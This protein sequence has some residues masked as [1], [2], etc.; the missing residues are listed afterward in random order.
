MDE[1]RD[2]RI[3][4]GGWKISVNGYCCINLRINKKN[5]V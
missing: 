5:I 2:E 3:V 1:I 4:K